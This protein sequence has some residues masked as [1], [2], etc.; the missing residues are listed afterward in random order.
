[1]VRWYVLGSFMLL[2]LIGARPALAGPIDF[3]GITQTDFS[4]SNAAAA[5]NLNY[6]SVPVLSSP[7]ALGEDLVHPRQW[8]GLGLG[9]FQREYELR[10]DE[11][12][13]VRR[14]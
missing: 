13:D 6:A 9:H 10:P 2:M 12:H 4:P 8:L 5:G 1:M 14:P 3:T 11:Q 7:T